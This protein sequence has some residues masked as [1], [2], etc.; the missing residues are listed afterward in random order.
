LEHN[1]VRWLTADELSGVDWL[2]ADRVL[3]PAL[4]ALLT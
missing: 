2:P 3:V 4:Q 1:A